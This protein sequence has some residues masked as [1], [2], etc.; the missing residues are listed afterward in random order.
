MNG[1]TKSQPRHCRRGRRIS[2]VTEAAE[3][4][5][6]VIVPPAVRADVYVNMDDREGN[7][8]T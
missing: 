6:D 8:L 2:G 5:V 3:V 1:A 7:V 4:T